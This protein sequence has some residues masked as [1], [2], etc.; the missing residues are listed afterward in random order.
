M[1]G[2]GALPTTHADPPTHL[3]KGPWVAQIPA[4]ARAQTTSEWPMAAEP[5]SSAACAAVPRVATTKA[6]I[7]LLEWP[8]SSA[9]SAP[10]RT[11][12]GR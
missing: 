7:M 8:G 4:A 9:C 10:S 5:P 11:A 6:A 3:K 2:V 1:C 12:R